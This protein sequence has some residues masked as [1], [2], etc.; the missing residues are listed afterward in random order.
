MLHLSFFFERSIF[1][2]E[3][4]KKLELMEFGKSKVFLF[5]REILQRG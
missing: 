4:K 5:E 3:L 1:L 2:F